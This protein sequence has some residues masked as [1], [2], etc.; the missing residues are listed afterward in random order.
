MDGLLDLASED[1]FKINNLFRKPSHSLNLVQVSS[2]ISEE[3]SFHAYEVSEA[4]LLPSLK[5]E[6]ALEGRMLRQCD[7]LQLVK[8]RRGNTATLHISQNVYEEVLALFGLNPYV[9]YLLG[10]NT[11]GFQ[12]IEPIDGY[13]HTFF[14]GTVSYMLAWA[15]NPSKMMTGAIILPKHSSHFGGANVMYQE[16]CRLL[17]RYRTHLFNPGL[18]AFIT[19]VHIVGYIDRDRLAQQSDIARIESATGHGPAERWKES[20]NRLSIGEVLEISGDVGGNLVNLSN[21][22]R[23][24]N[25]ATS[26]L[27]FLD[28]EPP[29]RRD[30][31][32]AIIRQ[33]HDDSGTFFRKSVP[34]LEQQAESAKHA[35]CFLKDRLNHQSTVVCITSHSFRWLCLKVLAFHLVDPR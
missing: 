35:I 30:Q 23:H 31:I 27:S 5:G 3:T 21:D 26:L 4:G 25:I 28:R 1:R 20:A 11:Y 24:I 16:F 17:H 13:F 18:L 12:Y 29:S 2:G 9:S 7:S 10:R 15:V 34:I 19:S 22:A 14:V 8:I 6:L 33:R 32:P